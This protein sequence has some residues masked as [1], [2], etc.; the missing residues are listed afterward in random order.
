MKDLVCSFVDSHIPAV[1]LASV[2][3]PTLFTVMTVLSSCRWEVFVKGI[4]QM[5]PRLNI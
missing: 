3:L 2:I 1:L 4:S 5:S